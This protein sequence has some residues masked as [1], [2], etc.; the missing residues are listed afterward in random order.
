MSETPIPPADLRER[1]ATA[2]LSSLRS[3]LPLTDQ[4]L[5]VVAAWLRDK[6][7]ERAVEAPHGHLDRWAAERLSRLADEIDPPK[8]DE[9]APIQ[10]GHV[11][12]STLA[13]IN[14]A[15]TTR[16]TDVHIELEE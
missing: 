5:P 4:I 14:Q 9:T 1:L 11:S 13:L 16:A 15:T 2:G 8:R 12:P 7:A 3:D 10:A 6:A